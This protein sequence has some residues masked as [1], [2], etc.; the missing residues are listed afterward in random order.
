M[1][2]NRKKKH[3]M[4]FVRVVLLFSGENFNKKIK[5]KIK[6]K[7]KRKRKKKKTKNRTGTAFST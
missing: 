1:E 2:N 3:H 5:I 6:K 7:E 4:E